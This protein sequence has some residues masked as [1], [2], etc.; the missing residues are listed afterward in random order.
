MGTISR[1]LP[2]LESSNYCRW[3]SSDINSSPLARWA[4][5]LGV[6][7]WCVSP[8][9][10]PSLGEPWQSICRGCCGIWKWDLYNSSSCFCVSW[11]SIYSFNARL[12]ALAVDMSRSTKRHSFPYFVFRFSALLVGFGLFSLILSICLFG[13]FCHSS[14]LFGRVAAARCLCCR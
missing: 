14:D 2:S 11:S 4:S 6:S 13:S 7:E 1:T 3:F 10:H 8:K 9:C 5:G 12:R